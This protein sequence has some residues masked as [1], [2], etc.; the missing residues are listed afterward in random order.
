[1]RKRL[2][3]TAVVSVVLTSSAIVGCS[4]RE[5]NGPDPSGKHRTPW[6][7]PDLQG[8][9]S[10]E[11]PTP[12]ERPLKGEKIIQTDEEAAALEQQLA[13][14]WE[15]GRGGGDDPE[16]PTGSYNAFW[17]IRGKPVLGRASLIIDP[18]D[19][20]LPPRTPHGEALKA[21]A[22]PQ[23]VS[24][25]ADNPEDRNE[26]ER[27]LHWERSISGVVNQQH[28]IVQRPGTSRSTRSACTRI[29]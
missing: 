3:A 7:D 8:L 18:S 20:R 6:G 5:A 19:G 13:K 26:G 25:P 17:Q 14:K 10:A 11:T 23:G 24:G 9:W 27:C 16:N 4:K 2:I 21:A 1:M 28:R 22:L 12:L 29:A 15:D